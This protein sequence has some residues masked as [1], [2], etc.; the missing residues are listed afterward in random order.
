MKRSLIPFVWPLLL[1][2][3]GGGAGTPAEPSTSGPPAEATA[4]G[5]PLGGTVAQASIGPAGGT[6]ASADGAFSVE[7][8]PGAFDRAQTLTLQEISNEAHGAPGRAWRLEPANLVPAQPL[9]LRFAYGDA[10]LQGTADSELRVAYQDAQ[11]RWVMPAE[12]T[13]DRSTR[14]VRLS[15]T[16]MGDWSRFARTWL[17]PGTATVTVGST[18]TLKVVRCEITG[19]NTGDGRSSQ[20]LRSCQPAPETKTMGPQV[21]GASGGGDT[22]GIVVRPDADRAEYI[23]TAPG[24]VPN[25]RTVAVSVQTLLSGPGG[26]TAQ[27]LLVSNITIEDGSTSC[28]WLHDTPALSYAISVLQFEVDARSERA[29]YHGHGYMAVTG[30]MVRVGPPA[31]G[32]GIV[33]FTSQN[34]P[35][36]G[37]VKVGGTLTVSDPD[38]SYIETYDGSGAPSSGD[39]PF[40]PALFTVVFDTNSCTYTLGGGAT[41]LA[42]VRGGPVSSDAAPL[43]PGALH[44]R[45]VPIDTS[46]AGTRTI[47]YENQNAP[48]ALDTDGI[49]GFEPW[50]GLQSMPFLSGSAPVRW[51]LKALPK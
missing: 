15:S 31:P 18:V 12:P 11:K 28:S 50:T 24:K 4:V 48:Y 10:D 35:A 17:V 22:V 37:L 23:Y 39:Q 30:R 25:P 33:V 43:A 46:V 40:S 38:H 47:A 16:Q 42:S 45:D 49:D 7:V 44:F 20:L 36:E 41:V 29:V 19:F 9:T 1:A 26:S 14:Q 6:L 5:Q 13:V 3:C 27:S 2:A 21:N 34:Q 32:T 8:P 51:E